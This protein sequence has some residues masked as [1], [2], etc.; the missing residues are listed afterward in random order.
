LGDLDG[1]A[2]GDLEGS[3]LGSLEGSD[4]GFLDGSDLG[5]LEPL[6]TGGEE[7]FSLLPPFSLEAPPRVRLT[8]PS[9]VSLDL[10]LSLSLSPP[11]EVS[12]IQTDMLSQQVYPEQQSVLLEQDPPSGTQES[13]GL[14]G[15]AGCSSSGGS[16]QRI[17]ESPEC[18]LF[19]D[20]EVLAP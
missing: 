10:L 7:V 12:G 3:D 9:S 16:A 14:T 4:F 5:C 13:G 20:L 15:V 19:G 17:G 11:L 8:L 2:L 18:E 6:S 1:S